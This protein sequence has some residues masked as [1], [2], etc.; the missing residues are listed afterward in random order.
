MKRLIVLFIL[1][2]VLFSTYA[3]SEEIDLSQMTPEE[4]AEL[5]SR[6]QAEIDSRPE[7]YTL[8]VTQALGVLK[9]YWEE[10]YGRCSS[11]GVTYLLDIRGVRI[12]KLKKDLAE[13]ESNLFGD[14]EYIIEFLYY[15]DYYSSSIFGNSGH[16]VGYLDIFTPTSEAVMVH[17]DGSMKLQVHPIQMYMS[18]Y[19]ELDYSL[20]I[21]EVVDLRDQYNQIIQF[22]Q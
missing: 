7:D 10:E 5:Q 4:L 11:P 16:N 13:R 6:I 17:Y 8:L 21:E 3:L 1:I 20:F 14:V 22:P 12:I 18:R 2:C 19:K 15:N 9:S